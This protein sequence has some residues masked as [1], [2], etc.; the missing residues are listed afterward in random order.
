M[1]AAAPHPHRRAGAAAPAAARD[2]ARPR[3]APPADHPR[4][5]TPPPPPPPPPPLPRWQC[6]RGGHAAAVAAASV[7]MPPRRGAAAGWGGRGGGEDWT[8][9]TPRA[10]AAAA[11]Q[12]AA[13][14]GARRPSARVAP[15]GCRCHGGGVGGG[16]AYPP[17]G[18]PLNGTAAHTWHGCVPPVVRGRGPVTADAAAGRCRAPRQA[19]SRAADAPVAAVG[20]RA[21]RPPREAVG[22]A[23]RAA[24]AADTRASRA[25]P[26]RMARAVGCALWVT[27]LTLVVVVAAAV[28]GATADELA[29]LCSPIDGRCRKGPRPVS[30]TVR[31]CSRYFP[32][33]CRRTSRMAFMGA[34]DGAGVPTNDRVAGGGR[35][36]SLNAVARASTEDK[37]ISE[38]S[39][40]NSWGNP[41]FGRAH[42]C[43]VACSEEWY[44][45]RCWSQMGHHTCRRACKRGFW[46]R[47]RKRRA[48]YRRCDAKCTFFW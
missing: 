47:R 25:V 42:V 8:R 38:C 4:G 33:N 32:E 7:A 39:R 21:V 5:G 3:R 43:R 17:P 30:A 22:C 19:R 20:G 31:C 2:A 44:N 14:V 34:S 26:L 27:A 48:C 28:A 9:P 16:G 13:P 29:G 1:G 11:P 24:A 37:C 10:V 6:H 36:G 23:R 45:D 46:H 18:A 41:N 35:L 15:A 40:M 12:W